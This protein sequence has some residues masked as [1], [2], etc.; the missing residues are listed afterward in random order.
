VTEEGKRRAG[1]GGGGGRDE[2]AADR[3]RRQA[4][5]VIGG[6]AQTELPLPVP[7]PTLPGASGGFHRAAGKARLEAPPPVDDGATVPVPLLDPDTLSRDGT[8]PP[9][10]PSPASAAAEVWLEDA[11]TRPAL[12]DPT[13]ALVQSGTNPAVAA[14]IDPDP[15]AALREAHAQ[16]QRAARKLLLL[17]IV[18]AFAVG[19]ALGVLLLR[20]WLR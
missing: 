4:Q 9:L 11:V 19:L 16:A 15:I 20:S 13:E 7:E 1:S 17:S 8:P 10:P 18:T 6:A 3:L 14:G 2:E 12:G 5:G